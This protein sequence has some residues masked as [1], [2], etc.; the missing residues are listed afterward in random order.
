LRQ[1]DVGPYG[2]EAAAWAVGRALSGVLAG[3]LLAVYLHGSAVLGGFR[4]DRSDLD[5]LALSR[6]LL[7]DEQMRRVVDA[8]VPL[9]YPAN[10]LEFCLM[11]SDEALAPELPAPRFQL[12]VA[13]GGKARTGK[14]VDGRGRTGDGNLVLH[15]AVARARGVAVLG[16]PPQSSIAAI[17]DE[18]VLSVMRDQIG[19]ARAHGPVEDLVLTSARVWLFVETHRISSKTEAG[20]W[21]AQRFPEPG[22]IEAAL[23]RQ[24]GAEAE[25][26]PAHAERLASYVEHL[27]Q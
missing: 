19:W 27:R 4:W 22:V 9:S 18:V 6:T 3:D 15:L 14:V 20:E 11:A 17:S 21:A 26:Q 8:L 13:T 23:S 12:R 7:P 25:I 2:P 5:V 16:P 10:G 1:D 24:R